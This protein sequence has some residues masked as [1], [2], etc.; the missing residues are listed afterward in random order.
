[1][2]ALPAADGR[3]W[4]K[5]ALIHNNHCTH[6]NWWFLPWHRAYLFYFEAIC[7]K[8]TGNNDFA[9]A[10]LELDHES[11]HP[12]ALLVRARCCTRRVE[13]LR[14]VSPIL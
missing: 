14:R 1:M 5:Q 11:Q 2:I 13:L 7:R 9:L 8:L 3:S 4:N 6:G 12:R 10:L